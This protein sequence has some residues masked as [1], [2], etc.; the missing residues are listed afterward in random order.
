LMVWDSSWTNSTWTNLLSNP[1]HWSASQH[2]V[3][4]W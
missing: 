1:A 2:C 4:S 3:F